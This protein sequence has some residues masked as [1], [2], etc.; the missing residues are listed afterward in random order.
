M[1][2]YWIIFKEINSKR[3]GI[4]LDQTGS[5]AKNKLQNYVA[6]GCVIYNVME[7]DTLNYFEFLSLRDRLIDEYQ[8]IR[9]PARPKHHL[10][11][12]FMYKHVTAL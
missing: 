8:G 3:K 9:Q 6:G 4:H 11:I 2:C 1:K 5:L 7:L 12:I 10:D